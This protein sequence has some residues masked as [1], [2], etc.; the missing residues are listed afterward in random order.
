MPDEQN[1]NT[2]EMTLEDF[3]VIF[4]SKSDDGTIIAT[5]STSWS[6][7]QLSMAL[8]SYDPENK[9]YSAYLN[10]GIS[11]SSSLSIEEIDELSTNTQ[12]DLSKVLKINAYN[13]KLIN[14][15]DIVGK[16]VESIETNINTE[17]K[18][19]Y[20]DVIEGRNRKR[21]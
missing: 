4:A 7:Q 20:G 14:K 11:P 15:N 5:S 3:D 6:S 2:E 17:A 13:R 19:I 21:N 12:N 16:T 10:E 1:S 9:K 8:S 18:L